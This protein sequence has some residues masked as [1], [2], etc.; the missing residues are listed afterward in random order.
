M[1]PSLSFSILSLFFWGLLFSFRVCTSLVDASCVLSSSLFYLFLLSATSSSLSDSPTTKSDQEQFLTL[2]PASSI[3][4]LLPSL[5]FFLHLSLLTIPKRVRVEGSDLSLPSHSVGTVRYGTCLFLL[6]VTCLS[7]LLFASRLILFPH[8]PSLPP[9]LASCFC[10]YPCYTL[11]SYLLLSLFV[12]V[13]MC[14]GAMNRR[15]NAPKQIPPSPPPSP[16]SPPFPPLQFQQSRPADHRHAL[17]LLSIISPI[18]L[19]VRGRLRGVHLFQS[20]LSQPT[21]K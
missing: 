1:H 20:P 13:C 2:P 9:A 16:L 10:V 15:M 18:Q 21:S 6:G 7:S 3:W 8:P 19:V 11:L 14:Y 17:P 12:S 5:P 4:W